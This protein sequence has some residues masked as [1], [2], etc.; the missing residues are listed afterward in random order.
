[1][2]YN[3]GVVCL[4]MRGVLKVTVGIWAPKVWDWDIFFK[5]W[6]R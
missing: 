6:E 2:I 1:M 4:V 5:Q 3:M